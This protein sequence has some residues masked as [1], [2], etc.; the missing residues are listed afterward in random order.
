M[1]EQDLADLYSS[2]DINTCALS[3]RES[4]HCDP[5]KKCFLPPA[6]EHPS[7]NMSFYSQHHLPLLH[8]TEDQFKVNGEMQ[9][10]TFGNA[11]QPTGVSSSPVTCATSPD[12]AKDARLQVKSGS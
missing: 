4:A 9:I 10:D 6:P 11:D 7:F 8:Q 3:R 12:L 5:D 1:L 2:D